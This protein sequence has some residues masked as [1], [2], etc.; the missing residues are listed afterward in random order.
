[1]ERIGLERYHEFLRRGAL[2]IVVQ[3]ETRPFSGLFPGAVGLS[4]SRI[5]R[6]EYD[7]PRGRPLLVLCDE[8]RLSMIAALY[9]EADGY[10]PAYALEGGRRALEGTVL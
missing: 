6:G 3:D 10:G 1:M 7:L 5:R 2:V 9:F 8:G 4:W